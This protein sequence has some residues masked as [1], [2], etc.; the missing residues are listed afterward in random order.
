MSAGRKNHIAII[1]DFD[2][3]L[4]PQDST[5]EVV[6][7]LQDTENGGLFWEYI[8]SLRGDTE[9][10]EW[11]HVLASDAPIW[12]YA[13]SRLAF[14][15]KVP[16]NHEFFEKFILPRI[17]LYKDVIGFLSKIKDLSKQEGFKKVGLDIHHFIVSAGLKDLIEQVF[18]DKLITE[19][20]GCRY[21]VIAHPDH[22]D[23][24]ESVPVFCMDES[25]KT[26]SIFEIV[27]GSFLEKDR[28]VN[29]RVEEA[30]RWAPFKNIIY[31]GDGFTDVPALSLVRSN[32][33]TGIAVYGPDWT[34]KRVKKKHLQLRLDK[35]ADFICAADYSLKADL[36]KYLEARCV[37]IRQRYEAEQS[38]E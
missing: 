34:T 26:R 11:Q 18:P 12:M 15:L 5:T 30:D 22:E 24:P 37:Q 4:T 33:G 35:R 1:W 14:N 3:T 21:T 7:F 25:M 28:A 8:K 2:G 36:Y 27:K 29:N 17:V 13:L 20:F 10:P 38:I 19:T 9:K 16:L 32:G 23:E 31:V 6:K